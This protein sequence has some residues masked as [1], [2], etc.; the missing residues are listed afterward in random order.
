MRG[1][2]AFGCSGFSEQNTRKFSFQCASGSE[3]RDDGWPNP[4]IRL[5]WRFG[6]ERE[7]TVVVGVRRTLNFVHWV[8]NS[9]VRKLAT[10]YGEQDIR[11][12]ETV[13]NPGSSDAR[14][15]AF[16]AARSQSALRLHDD[17][18][19]KTGYAGEASS[20]QIPVRPKNMFPV[21][22]S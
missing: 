17:G 10:A 14:P 13:A 8:L 4:L 12:L 11:E 9:S 3:L 5:K 1:S 16:P 15:R 2:G 19:A 6:L 20:R 22:V 21:P 7:P 18:G